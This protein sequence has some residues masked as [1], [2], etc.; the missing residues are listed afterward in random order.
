MILSVMSEGMIDVSK[1]S[2]STFIM[3]CLVMRMTL[4]TLLV[5]ELLVTNVD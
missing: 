5:Y 3:L 2:N 4:T 1:H